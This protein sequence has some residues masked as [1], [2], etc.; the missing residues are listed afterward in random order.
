MIERN[1]DEGE[2][3]AH[4]EQRGLRQLVETARVTSVNDAFPQQALCVSARNSEAVTLRK[5][6]VFVVGLERIARHYWMVDVELSSSSPRFHSTTLARW[7]KA[8][9]THNRV[10]SV[11]SLTQSLTQ[12]FVVLFPLMFLKFKVPVSVSEHSL[13]FLK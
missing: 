3:D 11:I 7:E 6:K 2:S 8:A 10:I 12:R 1:G 5:D 13:H 4:V 9:L